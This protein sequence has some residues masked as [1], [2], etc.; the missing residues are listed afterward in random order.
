M[1][2]VKEIELKCL[3]WKLLIIFTL[4]ILSV[5]IVIPGCLWVAKMVI[6]GCLRLVKGKPAEP[7]LRPASA[8]DVQVEKSQE[9]EVLSTQLRPA[10][11]SDVQVVESQEG[12]VLSTELRSA[13]ESDVHDEKS[14]EGEALNRENSSLEQVLQ[15]NNSA[16]EGSSGLID[17]TVVDDLIDIPEQYE[18]FQEKRV[19]CA[20]KI[21][22]DMSKMFEFNHEKETP[23]VGDVEQRSDDDFTELEAVFTGQANQTHQAEQVRVSGKELGLGE[24][25]KNHQ[26]EVNLL[27]T[28]LIDIGPS[29]KNPNQEHEF[30]FTDGK[31]DQ[32]ASNVFFA[33]LDDP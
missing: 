22:G 19:D 14:Q 18:K 1:S 30:S 16:E 20:T 6:H 32:A 7:K 24:E 13:P 33:N 25:A 17:G 12:E 15:I 2:L 27:D 11:E 9:G 4:G 10:P 8:S 5:Q 31:D 3:E 29:E 21:S 23:G 26:H 28:D